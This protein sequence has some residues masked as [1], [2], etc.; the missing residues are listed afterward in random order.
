MVGSVQQQLTNKARAAAGL[1]P[2]N[3]SSCLA[4]VASRH[5]MEMVVAGYIYHGDGVTRDLACGLR[6]TRAGEN[7]GETGAGMDDQGVFQAFMN[8]AGHRANILGAY[9]WIG[10]TWVVAANGTGY[11]SVE[12]AN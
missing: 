2:L 12:F 11:L 4:G 1:P 7:V 8:S 6:S 10:T 3:W 9:R 5:T